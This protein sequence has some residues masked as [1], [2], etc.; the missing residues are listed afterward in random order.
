MQV[1]VE[2]VDI[3]NLSTIAKLVGTDIETGD[4][5]VFGGDQRVC[6]D[7]GEALEV[8]EDVVVDVEDW[9]VLIVTPAS[10]G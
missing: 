9:Q 10:S 6:R 5:V 7:I 1:Q 3:P 4:R 8:G 2:S